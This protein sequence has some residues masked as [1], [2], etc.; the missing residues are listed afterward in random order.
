M[1]SS[2][3]TCVTLLSAQLS[4]DPGRKKGDYS[5]T[6]FPVAFNSRNNNAKDGQR[7]ERQESLLKVGEY[8]GVQPALQMLEVVLV[9]V[10]V[11]IESNS[12]PG[13]FQ[14]REPLCT[15]TPIAFSFPP[16]KVFCTSHSASH[17]LTF[18]IDAWQAGGNKEW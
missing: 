18:L 7:S 17:S 15:H 4:L 1:L 5:V 8:A 11:A 13:E 6:C 9:F 12:F 3:V 14:G 10:D 16:S 2:G